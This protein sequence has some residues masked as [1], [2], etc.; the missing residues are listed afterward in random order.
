MPISAYKANDKR[1][2]AIKSSAYG[3]QAT[4]KKYESLVKSEVKD[5]K[6]KVLVDQ[7][8]NTILDGKKLPKELQGYSQQAED[9][10]VGMRNEIDAL[11]QGLIDSGMITS[12]TGTI[13][14][15][16][17]G[18]EPGTVDIEISDPES[19]EVIFTE[20]RKGNV[21]N[22][23]EGESIDFGTL[24]NIKSNLGSYVTRAYALF[25]GTNWKETVSDQAKNRA[26]NYLMNE[27]RGTKLHQ[28]E[29]KKI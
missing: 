24:E 17:P 20:T 2:G 15:V 9:L 10:A 8:I 12:E 13:K 27:I 18:K 25:E 29:I 21:K 14:S 19:G 23:T 4:N 16:K 22:F 5:G 11:S 6:D 1:L 7:I 3:L 28:D 26:R